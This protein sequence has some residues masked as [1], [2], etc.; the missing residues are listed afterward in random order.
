MEGGGNN[1]INHTSGALNLGGSEAAGTLQLHQQNALAGNMNVA[2]ADLTE[3]V[4]NHQPQADSSS[5]TLAAED[6]S[7]G[8]FSGP[9]EVQGSSS[10][11]E[12][13]AASNRIAQEATGNNTVVITT[14]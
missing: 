2:S 4:I 7:G 13:H 1:S 14:Y 3:V 9:F 6:G 8:S 12:H 11:H 10:G 5:Y